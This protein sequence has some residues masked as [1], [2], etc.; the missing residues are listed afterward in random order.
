[1]PRPFEDA[2]A[3]AEQS[4]ARLAASLE[5]IDIEEPT[6]RRALELAGCG[7]DLAR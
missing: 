1:M 6:W 4:V 5:S 7:P 2:V 3:Q